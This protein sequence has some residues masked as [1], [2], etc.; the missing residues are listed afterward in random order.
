MGKTAF[1]IYIWISLTLI[2]G[3]RIYTHIEAKH[4]KTRVIEGRILTYP[5]S[6]GN[7]TY[8]K[9]NNYSFTIYSEEKINIGDFVRVTSTILPINEDKIN[10]DV[11]LEKVESKG[12]NE[13]KHI[14][15][16][17]NKLIVDVKSQLKE[18]Y[19]SFLLGIT[20]GY[21]ANWP[22]NYYEKFKESGIL[23][24]LVVSGFNVS[25][26]ISLLSIIL[27][28][29]NR[30]VFVVIIFLFLS[31]YLFIVGFEPPIIRAVIMGGIISISTSQGRYHSS[32]YSLILACTVI[33]I[34]SPYLVSDLSFILTFASTLAV[35]TAGIFI[36]QIKYREIEINIIVEHFIVLLF[37]N[38]LITPVIMFYFNEYNFVSIFTNL[39]IFW[40]VPALTILG[41][42]LILLIY[43]QIIP[44]LTNIVSLISIILTDYIL[45]V[46]DTIVNNFSFK[47]SLD[48]FTLLNVFLYYFILFIILALVY[49]FIKIIN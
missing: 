20:L 41:F 6:I 8:F 25:L 23:H 4:T 44:F 48:E 13:F 49:K 24:I 3:L 21:K 37:V 46:V 7:K 11:Y 35:L 34:V 39:L 12:I 16:F 32:F 19:A 27:S 31:I 33:L 40:T 43:I 28:K 1:L 5:R 9:I 42:L 15:E 17:K 14:N 22:Q 18:P 10:Y 47:V 36:Q 2:V 26:L 30:A 29:F 38:I 45:V